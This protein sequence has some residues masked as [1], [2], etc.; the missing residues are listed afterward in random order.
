LVREW[1]DGQV[2]AGLID[3]DADADSYS[4]SVEGTMVLADDSSPVFTARGMNAFGSMF[5][6]IEKL[7]GAFIGDG[8]LAWGEHDACLFKGTEW[9]FPHRLQ[10]LPADGL[11]SRSGR[12]SG[13]A[14]SW[15]AG[16]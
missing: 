5:R 15:R 3:Y 13:E 1:L 12:C 7:K 8:A 16:G 10:G 4:L 11:D 2:A 14:A 6:D 9:F